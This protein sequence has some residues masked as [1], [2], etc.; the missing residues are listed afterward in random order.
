MPLTC[1]RCSNCRGVEAEQHVL[2][3]H[4]QSGCHGLLGLTLSLRRVFVSV[5]C[6][7]SCHS[8][9]SWFL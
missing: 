9:T 1:D 6:E 7:R 4:S 8:M 2:I 5:F 3:G